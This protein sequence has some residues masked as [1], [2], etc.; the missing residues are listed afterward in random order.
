MKWSEDY[1]KFAL[2]R[3]RDYTNVGT[4]EKVRDIRKDTE[5]YVYKVFA[6]PTTRNIADIS[7]VT[8]TLTSG[9]AELSFEGISFEDLIDLY[10]HALQ[11]F[12]IH[13]DVNTD[14][15]LE[16]RVATDGTVGIMER[17]INDI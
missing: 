5:Y 2:R 8:C 14:R 10:N 12:I 17:R 13:W 6:D 3:L 7:Y 15:N 1:I 9:A 11:E 16:F 4:L